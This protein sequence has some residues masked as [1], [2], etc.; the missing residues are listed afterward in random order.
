MKKMFFIA[1]MMLATVFAQAQL[2]VNENGNVTI[3]TT[4][5]PVSNLSIGYAG[6]PTYKVSVTST[7]FGLYA[8][9][10]GNP[11]YSSDLW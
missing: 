6:N 3:N 10:M 4:E 2:R 11:I 5:T 9:R 8:R 1:S 7:D